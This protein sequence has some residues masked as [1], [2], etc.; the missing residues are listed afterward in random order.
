MGICEARPG[1]LKQSQRY[2]KN[3]NSKKGYHLCICSNMHASAQMHRKKAQIH[4][5]AKNVMF[6]GPEVVV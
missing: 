5:A 3:E 2:V 4:R 1:K 6:A